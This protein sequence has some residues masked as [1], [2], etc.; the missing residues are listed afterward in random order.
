M[1]GVWIAMELSFKSSG[2]GYVSRIHREIRWTRVIISRGQKLTTIDALSASLS[3]M[4]GWER[5]LENYVFSK[6]PR[7]REERKL[8]E[9]SL[10]MLVSLWFLFF[11]GMPLQVDRVLNVRPICHRIDQVTIIIWRGAR[12]RRVLRIKCNGSD[13]IHRDTCRPLV[14]WLLD[15]WGF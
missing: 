15:F 9:F 1:H 12:S 5:V 2:A 11:S 8:L 10:G 3:L 6:A 13:P 7:K 4:G 14:R